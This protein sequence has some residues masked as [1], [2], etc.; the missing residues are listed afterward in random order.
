MNDDI[1]TCP[2]CG[3]KAQAVETVDQVFRCLELRDGVIYVAYS[4]HTTHETDI[5]ARLEC[6]SCLY[7][8]KIP[9]GVE[10]EFE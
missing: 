1:L 8:I 10:V 4:D 9:D 2:R 7:E 5:G 6:R 3:G